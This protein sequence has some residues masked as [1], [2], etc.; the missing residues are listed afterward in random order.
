MIIYVGLLFLQVNW[1]LILMTKYFKHQFIK[2]FCRCFTV[3]FLLYCNN[4]LYTFSL[5][6]SEHVVK[7]YSIAQMLHHLLAREASSSGWCFE[8][9]YF[10][11]ILTRRSCNGYTRVILAILLAKTTF[12]GNFL[13]YI[14]S[15]FN[16]SDTRDPTKG[17]A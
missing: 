15:L 1:Q 11:T 14:S 8:S 12:I 17:R 9:S 16:T 7:P 13:H 6:C 4:L 10:S 2:V 3:A 5:W